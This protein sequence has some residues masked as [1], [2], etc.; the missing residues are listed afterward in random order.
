MPLGRLSW[1]DPQNAFPGPNKPGVAQTS[2]ARSP[3]R[4]HETHAGPPGRWELLRSAGEAGHHFPTASGSTPGGLLTRGRAAGATPSLLPLPPGPHSPCPW[5]PPPLAFSLR[6]LGLSVGPPRLSSPG[7]L[8]NP[9][10]PGRE[11]AQDPADR[12]G[13]GLE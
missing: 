1:P 7:H 5:L 9:E 12:A 8:P 4:V 13:P 11:A 10:L 6:P 2:R 3:G